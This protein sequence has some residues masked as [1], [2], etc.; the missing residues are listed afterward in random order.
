MIQ[1]VGISFAV[2]FCTLIVKQY[3]SN[4]AVVISLLGAIIVFLLLS[5]KVSSIFDSLV[6][7]SS[8]ISFAY[9]YIKLMIKVLGIIL[10]SQLVSD[11]CRD[12]GDSAMS[13]MVEISA[14][15]IVIT[16][17]LPLFE[18]VI[19]TVTGLLK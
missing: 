13:S 2:V 9:S 18:N 4:I 7:L 8:N 5:D 6:N 11:I 19:S 17:V 12:Y 16:M 10:V 1:I 3:N 15:I 14:R